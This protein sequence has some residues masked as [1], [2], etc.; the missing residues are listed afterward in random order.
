[1]RSPR[2]TRGWRSTAGL[3]PAADG[4]TPLGA[5]FPLWRVVYTPKAASKYNRKQQNNRLPPRALSVSGASQRA[6][7]TSAGSFQPPELG[8][9]RLQSV[10][11]NRRLRGRQVAPRRRR[12]RPVRLAM[13]SARLLRGRHARRV[14]PQNRAGG[15]SECLVG[16]RGCACP[17]MP[18]ARG[19]PTVLPADELRQVRRH[20][21]PAVA[22]PA[23]GRQAT[24]A[25]A[26]AGTA[27]G[28]RGRGREGDRIGP[29]PAPDTACPWRRFR[30][31]RV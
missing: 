1:M 4:G 17:A 13:G 23:A 12:R 14:G 30:A 8:W 10:A 18:V 24:G 21:F 28:G 27:C 2:C 7:I 11:K 5:W 22:R 9:H 19:V 31:G 6:T 16:R 3:R 15:R 20:A 26:V 29:Y 25:W